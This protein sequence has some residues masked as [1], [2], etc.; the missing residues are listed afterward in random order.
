MRRFFFVDKIAHKKRLA[1]KVETDFPAF[2]L[3]GAIAPTIETLGTK[4]FFCHDVSEFLLERSLG[5]GV[6]AP[7]LVSVEGTATLRLPRC[8]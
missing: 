1:L 8:N 3:G 4:I 7:E 6:L 2:A 5:T